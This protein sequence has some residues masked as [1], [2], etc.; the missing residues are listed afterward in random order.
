MLFNIAFAF[1]ILLI[2]GL[3][4]YVKQLYQN[5]FICLMISVLA[6]LI[7]WYIYNTIKDFIKISKTKKQGYKEEEEG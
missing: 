5:I 7:M 3:V 6:A 1:F 4:V 2:M